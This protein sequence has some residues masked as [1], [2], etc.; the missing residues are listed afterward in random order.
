MN[1]A[2]K[3]RTIA[4]LPSG[5]PRRARVS[6]TFSRRQSAR[7]PTL[8]TLQTERGDGSAWSSCF[9]PFSVRTA[10]VKPCQAGRLPTAT[11]PLFFWSHPLAAGPRLTLP[12]AHVPS[13]IAAH[14]G[15]DDEILLAALELIHRGDPQPLPTATHRAIRAIPARD[16]KTVTPDATRPGTVRTDLPPQ[17][18]PAVH[19]P[20]RPLRQFRT[21]SPTS[22][23]WVR[24]SSHAFG[25][26][27]SGAPRRR[28][29]GGP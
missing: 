17:T 23:V 16:A 15:E 1:H 13:P 11:A 5:I 3:T 24:K 4:S 27:A 9:E 21:G 6:M 25:K 12:P 10:H 28:M 14:R 20:D 8:P 7:K 19:H 26:K 2:S 18:D 29:K 22:H